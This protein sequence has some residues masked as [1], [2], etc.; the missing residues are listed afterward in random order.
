MLS[1]AARTGRGYRAGQ[2]L[3]FADRATLTFTADRKWQY[4]GDVPYTF[5]KNGVLQVDHRAYVYYMAL[6][7]SPAMMAKNIGVGSYYLWTY[8]DGAGEFLDGAKNYKLHIPAKVPIK[9]FWSVLVYDSLSRSELQN[10]Q[11]FPSVSLYSGPKVN[12]DGSVDVYFGP[13][14]PAGPG[15]ELD[16]DRSRQGMVPHLPLLRPAGTALR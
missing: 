10:G 6:G 13:E 15:E 16:Q 8:K 12:A 4:V 1:D 9:D 2:Q 5:V 11:P 7:N 3:R 14:M